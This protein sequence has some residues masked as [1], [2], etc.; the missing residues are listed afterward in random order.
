[1]ADHMVEG[2]LILARGTDNVGHGGEREVDDRHR[3][4]SGDGGGQQGRRCSGGW[5]YGTGM[6][7][8]PVTARAW[9]RTGVTVSIGAASCCGLGEER[10]EED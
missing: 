8:T 9:T 7:D 2:A 6:W 3:E 1:M 10:K 4:R 5:M